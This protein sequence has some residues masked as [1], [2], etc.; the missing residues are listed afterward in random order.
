MILSKHCVILNEYP[1]AEE[2]LIYQTRTQALVKVDSPFLSFLKNKCR[3]KNVPQ[4]RKGDYQR[5]VQKLDKMG[6]LIRNE[7]EDC[8]NLEKFF[9]QKKMQTLK[10]ELRIT[11]LMTYACNFKC[12]YCNEERSLENLTM[13]IATQ[14]E[15]LQYI[16]EKVKKYD[17]K[18]V[19]I[20]FYGG[21]PLVKPEV[22]MHITTH[23]RHWAHE[24]NI[25]FKFMLQTNG[26]LLTPL[27]VRA[28]IPLGLERVRISLD[29]ARDIHNQNRPLRSGGET[30]DVIMKNINNSINLIPIG[31]NIFFD[32][33]NPDDIE[34]LLNYLDEQKVLKK[35]DHFSFIPFHPPLGL[36]KV[37]SCIQ[38]QECFQHYEDENLIAAILKIKQML[39]ERDLPVNNDLSLS[40]C[41]L[42]RENGNLTIDPLG[43]LYKCN[44]ML[45]HKSLAIGHVAQATFNM[46]HFT[47]LS[48]NVWKSCPRDCAYLPL[49]GGGCRMASFLK[50]RDFHQPT[51]HK[52]YFDEMVPLL[53]KDKYEQ[54]HKQTVFRNTQA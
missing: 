7:D 17:F 16:K 6:I 9:Q 28:L 30:F 19:Y 23:L 31:L 40:A 1:Q 35:L 45:G 43:Y 2:H 20:V 51:C 8:V 22:V 3:F 34:Q 13:S 11:I 12:V 44:S 49:C 36:P 46:L 32:D 52:K 10:E 37:I 15:I 41:P 24:E 25:F 47:F 4:D 42:L 18:K 38:R 50:H 39:R 54:A 5:S 26:Y 29:G 53:I 27:I 48:L 33:K 21:E 14:T